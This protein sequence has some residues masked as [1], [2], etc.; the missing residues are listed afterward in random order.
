MVCLTVSA[1]VAVAVVAVA[2]VAVVADVVVAAA[3]AAAAVAVVVEVFV[4]IHSC[5]LAELR[6][7]KVEVVAVALHKTD[8]V[9]GTLV[10]DSR[11]SPAAEREGAAQS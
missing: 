4:R 7:S 5:A 8:D 1:G 10:V 11:D 2:V 6:C 3:A 9:L